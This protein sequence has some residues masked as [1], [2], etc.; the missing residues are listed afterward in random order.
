MCMKFKDVILVS[1]DLVILMT[2]DNMYSLLSQKTLNEKGEDECGKMATY[3]A[4]LKFLPY[5]EFHK[6]T[7]QEKKDI[8]EF[9]GA[10]EVIIH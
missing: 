1:E 7:E 5:N 9:V 4:Y 6:P 2:N 3:E 10:K 8:L